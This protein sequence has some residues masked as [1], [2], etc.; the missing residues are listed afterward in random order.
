MAEPLTK[1]VVLFS[2]TMRFNFTVMQIEKALINDGLRILKVFL[3]FHI[4]PVF[5]FV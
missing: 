1:M 3:K 5:T 2:L 4:P